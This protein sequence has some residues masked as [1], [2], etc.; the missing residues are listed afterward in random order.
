MG[1]LTK[2]ECRRLG[3][4]RAQALRAW[5]E[6]DAKYVTLRT[7]VVLERHADGSP[8]GQAAEAALKHTDKLW[9]KLGKVHDR[10][11]LCVKW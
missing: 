10:A 1:R 8:L 2:E 11:M 7:R 4:M 3:G 6:S 9:R 5:K